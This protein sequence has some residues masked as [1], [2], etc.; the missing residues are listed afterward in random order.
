MQEFLDRC[1]YYFRYGLFFSFFINILGLTFPIY[2]LQIFD[3]VLNSSSFPTLWVITVAAFIALTLNAILTWI[4]ARLLIRAGIEFDR[5]LSKPVLHESLNRAASPDGLNSK[6]DATLSDVQT[7]RNFMAGGP[8][9]A[10]F[11]LPWMPI[12]Y[13]VLF[14]LHTAMGCVGLAGGIVII[15]LGLTTEKVTKRRIA[16]ANSVNQK[17]AQISTASMRN[18]GVVKTMGMVPNVTNLWSL[19]NRRVMELQTVASSKAAI[20]NS[21]TGTFRQLM[22][23]LIYGV[24]CWLIL[25]SGASAGIM[26]AGSIVM[27]KALAPVTTIMSTYKNSLNAR[28]SYRRLDDFLK[29]EKAKPHMELPPPTG[30]ISAEG[31]F[32]ALKGRPVIKGASFRVVQGQSLAIIG[33]SAAGKSTLCKLLLNLWQ[34]NAGKVRLDRADITNWDP[35]KLGPYLGYLPQDVELFS[36]TVAENIARLGP[37]ESEKVIKAARLSG[38]H[39]MILHLARGYDTEVGPFGGGLSGGQRQRIG[40]ARALYGDPRIIVLD[41]PNSNLDEEGDIRLAQCLNYLHQQKTTVIM[42]THKLQI[43]NIVDSIM[44]MQDGQIVMYGPRNDV[45]A[46]LAKMQKQR[47]EEAKAARM[48]QE[49]IAAQQARLAAE[50]KEGNGNAG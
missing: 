45:L 50:K 12:Y 19:K 38:V 42:V 10:F 25:E 1:R 15:I 13:I 44:I 32:F 22:Q 6:N 37:V 29:A 36:G 4:R 5:I 2:M 43:L 30:E 35:D 26:I 21:V 48:R 33:P 3:K 16:D 11:D 28:A 47:E 8:I 14:M 18:A 40:L 31:L 49:E 7:L 46:Q 23:I 27:G 9:F 24:G 39:D 34:P 41:E 20:L 17:A